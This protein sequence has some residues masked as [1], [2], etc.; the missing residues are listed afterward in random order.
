MW[1]SRID[2]KYYSV[3]HWLVSIHKKITT[4]M[5]IGTYFGY[6]NHIDYKHAHTKKGTPHEKRHSLATV[7]VEVPCQNTAHLS[8]NLEV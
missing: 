7:Q 4:L 1:Q 3:T 2:I 5:N 6:N 8:T